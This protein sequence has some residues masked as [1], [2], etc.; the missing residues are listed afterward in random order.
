MEIADP[1]KT[2]NTRTFLV[3]LVARTLYFQCRGPGL[4]PGQGSRSH[5]P[6]LKSQ[7]SQINKINIKMLDIHTAI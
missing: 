2:L 6:Q 1:L 4:I 7:Y 5:V 3:D